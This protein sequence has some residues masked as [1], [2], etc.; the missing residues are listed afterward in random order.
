MFSN[1]LALSTSYLK[2]KAFVNG[3]PSELVIEVTNK[4]NFQ[5]SICP[6]DKI[7]RDI[8]EM[9]FELFTKIINEAKQY[10]DLVDLCLLGESLLH[11]QIFSM[12]DYC[13]KNGLKVYLQTNGSKLDKK[14]SENL[15]KSNPDLL[16]ISID[17]ATKDVY[18][19]IRQGFCFDKILEN[20]N[21][22][23]CLKQ[24]Y[25]S[26]LFIIIQMVL[27]ECNKHQVNEF[28][29]TWKKSS[30]NLV[31]IKPFFCQGGR[32][33]SSMGTNFL[34][35]KNTDRK[36][37]CFRLWNSMAIYWD[38]TVVPC[39]FDTD[40]KITL[41]NVNN[42]TIKE[43]WN[44]KEIVQLRKKH[45]LGSQGEIELC[46]N[47][48]LSFCR[49]LYKNLFSII[50]IFVNGLQMRKIFPRLEFLMLNLFGKV[51]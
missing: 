33:D 14:T 11:P 1:R 32:V 20:V 3:W 23:L 42:E 18:D 21:E 30:A 9:N 19:K 24:K 5:C 37:P 10:T 39:C 31:R 12:I 16:S 35:D 34:I 46:K 49:N 25:R 27:S 36:S 45:I 44:K 41:G 48:E 17:G 13:K 29:G 51:K 8:G 7:K 47:C 22:F 38:G 6:R 4:C 40:K 43:I 26:D 50:S 2:K 15:L 28:I